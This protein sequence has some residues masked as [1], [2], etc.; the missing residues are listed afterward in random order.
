[1]KESPKSKLH[2]RDFFKKSAAGIIGS[3]GTIYAN[4]NF[5]VANDFKRPSSSNDLNWSAINSNFILK[6]YDK[7]NKHSAKV[8]C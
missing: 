6:K 2:R 4:T 3:I 5:G 1:M 8:L 7:T